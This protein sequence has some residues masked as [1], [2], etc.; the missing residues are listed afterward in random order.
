VTLTALM[1]VEPDFHRTHVGVR[2]VITFHHNALVNAGYEVTLATPHRGALITLDSA[3]VSP[4]TQRPGGID[5]TPTWVSGD[6]TSTAAIASRS[7]S[8]APV[9][10]LSWNETKT[11]RPEDFDASILTNPW[12][13][14]GPNP[15]PAA[16]YTVGIAYDA[17]PI[18]LALG[19]LHL[20]RFVDAYRFAQEHD[21][22]YRFY[23]DHASIISCISE[24]TRDDLVR[25]YGADDLPDLRVD[26]PFEDVD[27]AAICNVRA[28][29]V[30]LVNALDPR[31]NIATAS[32][33]LRSCAKDRPLDITVVGRERMGIDEVST[34][35]QELGAIGATARWYRNPDDAT[36]WD[37]LGQAG[38]LLFPSVYEG[39]GL[40]ILEAQAVGTPAVS[41]NTSSCIEVNMNPGL[42]VDPYDVPALAA[43]LNRTLDSAAEIF[44]GDALRERQR[45]FLA[46]RARPLLPIA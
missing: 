25:L 16:S 37:L 9:A 15:P 38:A 32:T 35:L 30:V 40:P 18:L 5:N 1:I 39:L 42:A 17:V 3:Q 43:A 24:S 46:D 27:A 41:S 26:I 33:V 11:I 21:E 4:L 12:L 20:P 29:S 28:N 34:F 2:R 44:R 23:R 7:S 22:G 10:A 19:V 6:P 13:C 8:T 31:K 45:A 36:L 14:A